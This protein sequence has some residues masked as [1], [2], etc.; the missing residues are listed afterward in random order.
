[1]TSALTADPEFKSDLTT[2]ICMVVQKYAPNRRWHVDTVIKVLIVAGEYVTEEA[3]ANLTAIISQTPELHQYTAHKMYRAMLD[4]TAGSSNGITTQQTLIRVGVW[5]IGEYGD[6]LVAGTPA[7]E[8]DEETM[9]PV[10]EHDVIGMFTQA[11][12]I[13]LF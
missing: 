10:S 6:S 2:K 7:A 5:C 1:M 3:T 4:D 9:G 11:R 12:R 8:V 13:G